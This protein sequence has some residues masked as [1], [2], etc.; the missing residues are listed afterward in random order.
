MDSNFTC[1]PFIPF[2]FVEQPDLLE[3]SQPLLSSIP[4]I[5]SAVGSSS[6]SELA[7]Q[8]LCPSPSYWWLWVELC[9]G[10]I[11]NAAGCVL[12]RDSLFLLT[13]LDRSKQVLK[14]H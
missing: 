11:S 9:G 6:D 2:N 5:H 4:C 3:A 12:I 13:V 14:T 1:P 7:N 8:Y 10:G